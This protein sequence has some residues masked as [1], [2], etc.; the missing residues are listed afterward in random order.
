MTEVTTLLQSA[1]GDEPPLSF[2]PAD[3]LTKARLAR[4][5]LRRRHVALTGT[6]GAFVIVALSLALI[7][8]GAS[9]V[10]STTRSSALSLV[11]LEKTAAARQ[12]QRPILAGS[13]LRIGG[14]TTSN[15]AELVEK[16]TGVKLIGVNVGGLPPFQVINLAAGIDVA[17]E[18]YLNV[19]VA[20]EHAMV[21]ALPTCAQMSDLSSGDG[22]GF[23]GPCNITKLPDGSILVTRSGMTV[24]GGFTMAQALL[25]NPDGSGIFAENTN[26]TATTPRLVLSKLGVSSLRPRATVRRP[27]SSK[28]DASSQP[29]NGSI[30]RAYETPVVRSLPVLD[31]KA[32]AILVL[33]LSDQGAS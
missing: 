16:D 20:P 26:Q 1:L 11:A 22:D 19:Q 7:L 12:T 3:V 6:S 9:K 33:D 24:T 27:A 21:T 2:D 29:S 23:Y 31:A 14:I 4:Q 17:G 30:R 5:R 18:P 8:T 15:L 25:V 13:A 10:H 28:S 32:M